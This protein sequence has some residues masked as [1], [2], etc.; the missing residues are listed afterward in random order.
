MVELLRPAAVYHVPISCDLGTTRTVPLKPPLK[1]PPKEIGAVVF[2]PPPGHYDC[3]L[4]V[5]LGTSR[6]Q[7]AEQEATSL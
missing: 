1:V 4:H 3:V 6:G 2:M 7:M 5:S